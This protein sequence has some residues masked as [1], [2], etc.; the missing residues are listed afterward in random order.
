MTVAPEIAMHCFTIL[1]G[2]KAQPS[3]Y[4]AAAFNFAAGT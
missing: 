2:K 3:G 4:N 1:R